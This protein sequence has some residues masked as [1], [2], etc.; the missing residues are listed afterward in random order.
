MTCDRVCVCARARAQES[1]AARR[2]RESTTL[3]T[4]GVHASAQSARVS[5]IE[6]QRAEQSKGGEEGPV[7]RGVGTE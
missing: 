7:E 4:W 5:V 3:P 6:G 1:L 2:Y